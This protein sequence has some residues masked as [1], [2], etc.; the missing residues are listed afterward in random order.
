MYE[1]PCQCLF[2]AHSIV[3][4]FHPIPRGTPTV[5]GVTSPIRKAVIPAAGLGTRML[6]AAKAVPKP[7]LPL[8][9]KP[10]IQHIVDELAAC[11]VTDVLVVARRTPDTLREHFSK[12][13]LLFEALRAKGRLDLLAL[14]RMDGLGVTMH[15]AYQENPN[16]LADA[17]LCARDF[18]GGDPFFVAL[19]D[20]VISEPGGEH[21]LLPAMAQAF[22][23]EGV[24]AVFGAERVPSDRI[25]FYGVID[26]A[27]PETDGVVELRGVVE[28]PAPG[29]AP[30]DLAI[31]GRYVFGT[32]IF[33]A[34]LA[35]PEPA[36]GERKL[37]DA[38]TLQLARGKRVRAVV[39]PP[40]GVRFDI[41][42]FRTYFRAF[43]EFALRDAD[44]GPD[45]SDYLRT[46][47]CEE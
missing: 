5:S 37:P 8:G 10:V 46:R 21:T 32:D 41:G 11:G 9:R 18:V 40:G 43:A 42:D 22:A 15:F 19:G 45:F 35:L 38:A 24:A 47:I 14:A 2:A 33:E 13:E 27:G 39:L 16:G 4:S 23:H 26:P 34:I 17:L 44:F 29:M 30:S 3:A 6:P 7:M 20:S 36:D 1:A 25:G 12:D 31:A 28:K